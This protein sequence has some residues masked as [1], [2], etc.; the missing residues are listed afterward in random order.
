MLLNFFNSTPVPVRFQF[1]I[2]RKQ[3]WL[4]VNVYV[5]VPLYFCCSLC[6]TEASLRNPVED[7]EETKSYSDLIPT[8]VSMSSRSVSLAMAGVFYFTLVIIAILFL[9]F[10]LCCCCCCNEQPL[11]LT[12]L[13][14]FVVDA[15]ARSYAK[16]QVRVEQYE[17]Y[18]TF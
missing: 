9:F 10:I 16:P 14:L 5:L 1:R 12:L 13:E 4:F 6:E 3:R 18:Q 17:T 8:P 15:T 2:T 7:D 11:W